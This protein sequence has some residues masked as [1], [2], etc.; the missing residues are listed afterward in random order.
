MTK[1][2]M[3]DIQAAIEEALKERKITFDAMKV[4]VTIGR[5]SYG[6]SNGMFKIEIADIVGGVVKTKEAQTLEAYSAMLGLPKDIVG[7]KFKFGTD[8]FTVEG[9]KPRGEKILIKKTE[10]GKTYLTRLPM[11]KLALGIKDTDEAA[12]L[13]AELAA[14]LAF[15]SKS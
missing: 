12:E 4:K 14:E 8:E 15:E 3:K 11:L 7:T 9:M 6:S 10:N 5:G 13:R 1:E 2:L